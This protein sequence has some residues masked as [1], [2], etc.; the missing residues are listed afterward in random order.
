M[1]LYDN[2]KSFPALLMELGE[3]NPDL[4]VVSQDMGS[5]GP[6]AERFPERAIDVGITEQ[7]LIGV[8]AGLAVRGKL[9]FVYGMAPFVTMRAFE[10]IRTDLAYNNRNVKILAVFTGL[11]AGPWGATHHA[12]EDI[13]LMRAIPSMTILVPADG[14]EAE[15]AIRA[16]ADHAGPVYIRMGAYLPVH[17]TDYD[18]RV[19]EA[20]PL[21]EGSDAAIIATGTMVPAALQAHDR[22]E[23]R[24]VHARVL[25][26][27]TIKP[28]DI[29][30]VLRAAEETG[31]V[32]TAEE[33]SVIGGLGSAVAEAMAGVGVGRLARVGIQDTFCTEV[34]SYPE[35]CAIHGL[36]AE[37][38]EQAVVALLGG[39]A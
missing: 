8:S 1:S 29:A 31:H 32:V 4:F 6:F 17:D 38:I 26:V 36:T 16:A 27:H 21:R 35:L 18:F 34:A 2:V 39:S 28:L 15:Q 14:L 11:M 9:A 10:Q 19:G 20:I 33:H 22:L 24:G 13:A 12:Q 7:N 30:A 37:G 25:D 3:A 5:V 23:T